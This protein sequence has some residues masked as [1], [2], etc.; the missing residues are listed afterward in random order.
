MPSSQLLYSYLSSFLVSWALSH[1]PIT[2]SLPSSPYTL[3]KRVRDSTEIHRLHAMTYIGIATLSTCFKDNF[4]RASLGKWYPT[5]R[6]VS[7]KAFWVLRWHRN[8]PTLPHLREE[9]VAISYSSTRPPPLLSEA[10]SQVG[11]AHRQQAAGA[12]PV[13]T[14]S[15]PSSI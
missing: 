5:E 13:R 7:Q 15:A 11:P 6:R 12:S 3:S 10:L 8:E 2:G 1:L 9:E 4:C 14:S